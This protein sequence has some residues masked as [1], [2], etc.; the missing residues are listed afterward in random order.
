MTCLD[1][2]LAIFAEIEAT[3]FIAEAWLRRAE[4]ALADHD[5]DRCVADLD[6]ANRAGAGM[7]LGAPFLSAA[8]RLAAIAALHQGDRESYQRE[9]AAARTM[10]SGLRYEAALVLEVQVLDIEVIDLT[11]RSATA[12]SRVTAAFDVLGVVDSGQRQMLPS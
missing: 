3:D 2:A 10:T 9:L 6:M 11:R 12:T 4:V 5:P 1:E 7:E 8:H